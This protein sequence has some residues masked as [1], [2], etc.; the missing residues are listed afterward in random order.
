MRHRRRLNHYMKNNRGLGVESYLLDTVQLWVLRM[1]ID[2]CKVSNISDID[3]NVLEFIEISYTNDELKNTPP[4]E[5][6]EPI[7]QK[8]HE[9]ESKRIVANGEL[10][11]NIKKLKQT[12]NLNI[13]EAEILRFAILVNEYHILE[14]AI[15]ETTKN[16]SFSGLKNYLTQVLDIPYDLVAASL[17]SKSALQKSSILDVDYDRSLS[18]Y[19]IDNLTTTMM[20]PVQEISDLIKGIICKCNDTDL[21]IADFG[22][23]DTEVKNLSAYL[24]S[25]CSQDTIP[26]G[27]NILLYGTP[28]TGKTELTKVLAAE[29]GKELYEVAYIDEDK[30]SIKDIQRLKSFHISQSILDSKRTMLLFDEVEEVLSSSLFKVSANKALINRTLE[31]SSIVSIWITNDVRSIDD[32][33]LRRFSMVLEVP[34]PDTEHR[35]QIVSKYS[36]N[37]ISE[38]MIDKLSQSK[39]ISPAMISKTAGVVSHLPAENR[40]NAFEMIVNSTLKAQGFAHVPNTNSVT[41]VLKY[42]PSYI[43]TPIDLQNLTQGIA[44]NANVRICIYGPAGTGKSEY[45]K[46]LAK[47]LKKE[48]LIKKASDIFGSYVGETERNIAKAFAEAKKRSAVLVFDEVD[49]FLAERTS[50]VRNWERTQVNEL[51]VQI[52][53]F[54][55]I[56]IATT[57]LMQNLDKA[58]LRRFDLKLEFGYLTATQ[59]WKMLQRECKEYNI[60]EPTQSQKHRLAEMKHLT[61]GDFATVLR[62]NRFNPIIDAKDFISRLSDE[63][64]IKNISQSKKIGFL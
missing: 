37:L 34:I 27:I 53:S 24:K 52:E 7:L 2:F 47:E 15:G 64:E 28:G 3:E 54:E 33:Y 38:N 23:I 43:N 13:A 41:T 61:P 46:Y 5:L 42:E 10:E 9:L 58:S 12:L 49:S 20:Q 40:D 50:A 19:L 45:A 55:G 8:K 22:Y 51:L 17:S 26:N 29:L 60:T 32:A 6:F 56:F 16:I 4:V 62:Q 48:C 59:A 36:D 30:Q 57:N 44:T 35:K 11:K 21:K 63:Q 31:D 25:I 1:Y 18:F 39:N 14:T